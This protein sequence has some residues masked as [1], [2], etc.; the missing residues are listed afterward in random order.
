MGTIHGH[1]VSCLGSESRGGRVSFSILMPRRVSRRGCLRSSGCPLK[2]LLRH[3]LRRRVHVTV[4]GLPIRYEYIFRGDEFRR[5]GCRRVSRRL[6][7]SVGAI[8]CR[9]GGTLSF[10]RAR[11]DGCLVTLVLFFSYWGEGGFF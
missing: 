3:R 7:V 5:G 4:S 10:L 2:V 11:L 8:G 6:N 9:V 1:Y